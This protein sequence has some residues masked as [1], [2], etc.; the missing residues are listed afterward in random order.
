MNGG[1]LA[2]LLEG[3]FKL[4][5]LLIRGDNF[6]ILEDIESTHDFRSISIITRL[7]GEL[8]QT[9]WSN[10]FHILPRRS[11]AH[12]EHSCCESIRIF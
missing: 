12:W 7:N 10:E 2:I 3:F 9:E 11:Y 5:E 1:G 6:N 8:Q 4:V